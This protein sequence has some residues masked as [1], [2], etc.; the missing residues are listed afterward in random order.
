MCPDK[1][2]LSVY[3]DGELPERFRRTLEDHLAS[4]KQCAKTLA[5][6]RA[7]SAKLSVGESAGAGAEDGRS[8]CG[9]GEI[10]AAAKERVW[11]KLALEEKCSPK[12]LFEPGGGGGGAG[13]LFPGRGLW[14]KRVSVP[15]P[16]A[17]AAGFL[18]VFVSGVLFY[19]FSPQGRL[20]ANRQAVVRAFDE[21]PL[22][23]YDGTNE[24]L[25]IPS[26]T[27]ANMAEVLQYLD[28]S[29]A[30]VVDIRLPASR[31]FR[32]FGEPKLINAANYAG[33][34]TRQ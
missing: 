7:L 20:S 23:L 25:I 2:I 34:K 3:F 17:A 12:R 15:L 19:E 11:A 18:L 9:D 24:N 32:S 10:I 8:A 26:G 28:N 16:F 21:N 29:N 31:N 30:D 27:P 4:C 14:R 1:Q 6:F 13:R 22:E 33:R 5:S